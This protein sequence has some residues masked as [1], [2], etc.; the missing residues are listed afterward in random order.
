MRAVKAKSARLNFRQ[1]GAAVK[2]GKV[3]AKE[4]VPGFGGIGHIEHN[5]NAVAQFN[6]R[7]HRV[8]QAS[9]VVALMAD[10]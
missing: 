10:D 1:V 9:R 6:G 7:F 3:L 4:F 2:A 8:G 5:Q